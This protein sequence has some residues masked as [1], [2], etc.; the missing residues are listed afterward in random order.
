MRRIGPKFYRCPDCQHGW[1]LTGEQ[2]FQLRRM[3][4]TCPECGGMNVAVAQPPKE[5]A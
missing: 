1:W 4:P 3:T 5:R 2:Q